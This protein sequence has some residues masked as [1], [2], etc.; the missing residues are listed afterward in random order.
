MTRSS[1]FLLAASV[2]VVAHACTPG[3]AS[4]ETDETLPWSE[5]SETVL[6]DDEKADSAEPLRV[7]ADGMT[8]WFRAELTA[9]G[10]GDAQ[11]FVL[12]GR[13]S[14]NL[15]DAFSFVPD[16]AFG[17]TTVTGP[18]T[19]EV[20]LDA[21][22]TN[23]VLFGNRLLVRL[24]T[25]DGRTYTAMARARARVV[26]V[27][28]SGAIF[29]SATIGAVYVDRAV[30]YRGSVGLGRDV[31][32]LGVSV[33]GDEVVPVPSSG[34]TWRFDVTYP[35]LARGSADEGVVY[36]ATSALGAAVSRSGR[37]SIV[38]SEIGATSIDPELAWP[39]D[40]CEARVLA[41]LRGIDA[42]G[43]T[44]ACG[45]A[46]RVTRCLGALEE[47]EPPAD[48]LARTF[49]GDLE[50]A[51]VTWYAAHGEDARASGGNDLA[52]AQSLVDVARVEE[53]TTWEDDPHAH[54]LGSVRVMRH[55]DVVWP[56]SDIVWFGAYDR[57]SGALLEIYEFN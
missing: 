10:E 47:E 40:G 53:I 49:A 34:R 43:D 45:D 56:G 11:R 32:A 16:D 20:E 55:P 23:S 54:D 25:I 4:L 48:E 8:I 52:T 33:G 14:R 5:E 28:G 36:R 22:E 21:H 31:S 30:Q 44:S 17:R 51:L 29:P 3:D 12:R 7:R 27:T 50:G 57:A 18:R 13:T 9:I 24:E 1:L 37:V 46:W 38:T 6:V 42:S 39:H 41:C 35:A 19:F 2:L 26:E 15:A